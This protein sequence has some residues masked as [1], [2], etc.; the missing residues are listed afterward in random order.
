MYD[1]EKYVLTKTIQME[2]EY[3]NLGF[4]LL[5]LLPLTYF[6]FL[7][8]YIGQFPQFNESIDFYVHFH[9]ALLF[10]WLVMLILQPVLIRFQK[11][12]LH[13]LIGKLSYVLFPLVILTFVPMLVRDI[14]MG[15]LRVLVFPLYQMSLLSLF[16]LLAIKNR[17]RVE[18]HMRFMIATAM[19]FIDPTLGRIVRTWISESNMII[20]HYAFGVNDGILVGLIL[21]DR[22][23][24]NNY[25]PYLIAL[26]CFLI[27]QAIAYLVWL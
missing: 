4:Y 13:R 19:V 24:G 17:K 12:A 18:L 14:N 6:G 2:K 25:K 23:K 20:N 10:L 11:Y 8:S 27:C 3:K 26:G 1:K 16:Y 5:I 7:E 9:V 22:L 15:D 21:F